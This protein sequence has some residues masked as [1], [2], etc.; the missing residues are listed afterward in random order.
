MKP[1]KGNYMKSI[2]LNIISLALVSTLVACGAKDAGPKAVART[3]AAAT[4]KAADPA[5]DTAAADKAAADKEAADKAGA[6]TTTTTATTTTATTTTTTAPVKVFVAGT[7]ALGLTA[8]PGAGLNLAGAE[9]K[10]LTAMKADGTTQVVIKTVLALKAIRSGA[11]VKSVENKTNRSIWTYY[12]ADGTA[13]VQLSSATLESVGEFVTETDDG[14]L[15]FS[16]LQVIRVKTKTVETLKTSVQGPKLERGS[17][18]F[19]L[20]TGLDS[21]Q[22]VINLNTGKRITISTIHDRPY[23]VDSDSVVIGSA[24]KILN[25]TTGIYTDLG[26]RVTVTGVNSTQTQPIRCQSSYADKETNSV[27][28]HD[29]HVIYKVT[30][31]GPT[32][33]LDREYV[34]NDNIT[35]IKA[36]YL[37]KTTNGLQLLKATAGLSLVDTGTGT[38]THAATTIDLGDNVNLISYDAQDDKIIYSVEDGFGNPKAGTKDV[39]TSEV[40]PITSAVKIESI[41]ALVTPVASK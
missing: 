39:I 20:L 24:G 38:A 22:Q 33:M 19:A 11:L 9:S 8:G 7:L 28:C 14:D 23:A 2:N 15:W 3:A 6:T 12:P 4:D 37:L 10:D 30:A 18:N 40:K 41:S 32:R 35:K 34:T 36:G 25:V 31:T 21:L 17:R 29:W 1:T 26:T 13:G 5:P 27:I 16:D